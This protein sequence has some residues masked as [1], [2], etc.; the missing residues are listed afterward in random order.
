ME[1]KEG[2]S[3]PNQPKDGMIAKRTY[4]QRERYGIR[5]YQPESHLANTAHQIQTIPNYLAKNVL[6]QIYT[7]NF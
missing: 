4:H 1:K 6:H 7:N 2:A 5:S 3:I